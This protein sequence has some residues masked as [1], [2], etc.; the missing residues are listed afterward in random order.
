M[1]LFWLWFVCSSTSLYSTYVRNLPQERI[2]PTGLESRAL[3]L[4]WGQRRCLPL[5]LAGKLLCRLKGEMQLSEGRPHFPKEPEC[6]LS[7][8]QRP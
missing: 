1:E 4:S 7:S 5:S 3:S 2:W 8:K 6:F